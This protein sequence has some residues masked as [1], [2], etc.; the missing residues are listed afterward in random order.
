MMSN[1][2]RCGVP[3]TTAKSHS[4]LPLT[5]CCVMCEVADLGFHLATFEALPVTP[6]VTDTEYLK[7]LTREPAGTTSS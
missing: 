7:E 3:Y 5:Y 6:R 1:C 2:T 4:S